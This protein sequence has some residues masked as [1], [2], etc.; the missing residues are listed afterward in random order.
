MFHDTRVSQLKSGET[1]EIDV[2]YAPPNLD[3]FRGDGTAKLRILSMDGSPAAGKPLLVAYLDPN[4]GS[5][6]MYQGIVP[7]SG[8]LQFD[9]LT[10]RDPIGW[11]YGA[12]HVMSGDKRLGYFGFQPGETQTRAEFCLPPGLGDV[13]PNVQ[14]TEVSSGS[15]VSLA[16][17]R[18]KVVW[19]EFWATWCGPCQTPIKE[20][21]E[22]AAEERTKWKDKVALIAV[23]IDE[24]SADVIKHFADAVGAQFQS[25]GPALR[26]IPIDLVLRPHWHVHSASTACQ[27]P[28]CSTR[29]DGFSGLDIQLIQET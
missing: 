6:P 27:P 1:E 24:N 19:L 7:E 29:R 15:L 3:S 25:I 2:V 23:S 17:F 26:A 20:L 21:N 12:Y 10:N 11:P 14:F 16:D 18:G 28:F 13:A 4:Y 22:V 9:H 5:M 8:E